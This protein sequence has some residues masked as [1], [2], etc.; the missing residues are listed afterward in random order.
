MKK[1]LVIAGILLLAGIALVVIGL[2]AIDF[3][4]SR[5]GRVK[6]ESARY[7]C[8][9]GVRSVRVSE[10][11]RDIEIIASRDGECRLE[12]PVS[13]YD[14]YEITLEDG[15]LRVS[16]EEKNRLMR[17]FEFARAPAIKLYLPAGDYGS[18]CI[19]ASSSDVDVS[20]GVVFETI[21][22]RL[23]SGDVESSADAG[24]IYI[25]TAS[26]DVELENI[27]AEAVRVTTASGDVEANNIRV[28]GDF[29]VSSASG[30]VSFERLDAASVTI[31]TASGDVTGTMAGEMRY[32]IKTASGDVDVPETGS[33]GECSITTSSGDI[34]IR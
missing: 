2:E 6:Y 10:S 1:T 32:T 27:A 20:P 24:R 3:D 12:Y 26:G 9:T 33:G 30:D 15:E 31:S 5:L 22:A 4:F 11:S 34:E 25:E 16:R 19:D 13:E 28:S 23:S 7:I 29:E 17:F 14:I 21:E 18:L 8:E